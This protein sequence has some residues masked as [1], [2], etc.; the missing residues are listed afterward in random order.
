M[1]R[2]WNLPAHLHPSVRDQRGS[3]PKRVFPS[4]RWRQEATEWTLLDGRRHGMVSFALN[5]P[6]CF[7]RVHAP[8]L[9]KDLW[10]LL[11]YLPEIPLDIMSNTNT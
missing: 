11:I 1:P 5:K 10:R 4:L 7:P 3:L 8:K 6:E 9:R 2:E